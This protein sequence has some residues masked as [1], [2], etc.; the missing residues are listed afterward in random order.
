M[1]N[2][3]WNS[4]PNLIIQNALD[5]SPDNPEFLRVPDSL[6]R[7]DPLDLQGLAVRI[8]RLAWKQRE[9]EEA[10]AL[11]VDLL[12]Q[13][14]ARASDDGLSVVESAYLRVP[15]LVLSFIARSGDAPWYTPHDLEQ[16]ATSAIERWKDAETA[17]DRDLV[18]GVLAPLFNGNRGVFRA[19]LGGIAAA[20]ARFDAAALDGR[21]QDVSSLRL[22]QELRALQAVLN[23]TLRASRTGAGAGAERQLVTA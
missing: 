6:D 5:Q 20:I 10:L 22:Y 12:R 1:A 4:A 8:G 2:R 15:Q 3:K 17:I 13:L 21:L 19:L 18:S 9:D 14:E 11:T 7:P 23:G 16:L